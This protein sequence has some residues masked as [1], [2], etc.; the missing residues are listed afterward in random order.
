MLGEGGGCGAGERVLRR[1]L[2]AVAGKPEEGG[3]GTEMAQV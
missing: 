3:E 1:R 2:C